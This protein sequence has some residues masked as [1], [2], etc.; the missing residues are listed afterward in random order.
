VSES[1]LSGPTQG[2]LRVHAQNRRYFADRDGRPVYLTGSHTWANLQEWGPTS[3]PVPFDYPKWLDFMV[4]HDHNFMRMWIYENFRWAVWN[5]VDYFFEPLPWARTGPG[6]ALDGK[7]KF[8]LEQFDPV[9]F[10]RMRE[11]VAA[12]RDRGIYVAVMLFEGWSGESKP[13]SHGPQGPNPWRG[14][15][16]HAA[17]N[18]ND[19]DGSMP[20]GV[21][22]GGVHTLRDPEVIRLQRKYAQKVVE[23]VNDLDNVLYEIGN[24]HAA[25]GANTAWQYAMIEYLRQL[26]ESLP[27]QHPVLMTGQFP[28]GRNEVLFAGPADA[29]SPLR[30][31]RAGDALWQH[32]PPDAGGA[33][34]V[35]LDTDHLWGVGGTVDWVWK[36]FTRGNNPI[37]MDPWGYNHV[38]PRP[39]REDVRQ[40]MGATRRLAATLDLTRTIPRPDLASTGY[41]LADA[42]CDYVI[43]Q[44]YEGVL[45]VDLSDAAGP[46]TV[47]WLDPVTLAETVGDDVSGGAPTNFRS[48]FDGFAVLR[49]SHQE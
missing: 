22:E 9:W 42:G 23:T 2:P 39:A 40:A 21:G 20:G 44:P 16:F 5:P 45:G 34:V 30:W 13:W 49:L 31:N 46:L 15:P 29:V 28:H 48:P 1:N 19:V 8:D 32:D 4:A 17:N 33:K 36:S 24:E 35:L 18:I 26:E 7:P 3:P 43:F 38:D 6:E 11:R 25:T 27:W 41:A 14:N 12:A 10:E 47:R 37:Y